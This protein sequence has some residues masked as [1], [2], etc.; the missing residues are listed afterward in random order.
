MSTARDA[1]LCGYHGSGALAGDVAVSVAF[2]QEGEVDAR[3]SGLGWGEGGFRG[4]RVR[5]SY[6]C[7]C[8]M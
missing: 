6:E 1:C 3:S 5:C 4:R 2:C 8:E 7:E